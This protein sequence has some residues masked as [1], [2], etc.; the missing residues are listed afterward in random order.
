MHFRARSNVIQVIRTTYNPTTKRPKAQVL[1]TFLKNKPEI[2]DELRLSCQPNELAEIR[3][4]IK[5]QHQLS[6]LELEMAARTLV[7]QMEKATEWFDTAQ[8]SVEN[9]VLATEITQ[10]YLVLRNKMLRLSATTGA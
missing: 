4:Y 10:K 9:E 3:A 8:P 6:R 1:G 5:N 2:G 7:G